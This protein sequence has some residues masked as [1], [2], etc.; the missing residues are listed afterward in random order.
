MSLQAAFASSRVTKRL[1]AASIAFSSVPAGAPFAFS[2]VTMRPTA[3]SAAPSRATWSNSA[4]PDESVTASKSVSMFMAAPPH[5][6]L[7]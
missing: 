1:L 7:R 6:S 2:S 3:I 5:P 4:L